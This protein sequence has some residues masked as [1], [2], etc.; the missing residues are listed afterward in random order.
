MVS[1]LKRDELQDELKHRDLKTY[2][3][4]GAL[5]QR[6]NAAIHREINVLSSVE[7]AK[8][9]EEQDAVRRFNF[10]CNPVRS[11]KELKSIARR[12]SAPST[13]LETIL[14]RT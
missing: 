5:Q 3:P 6:L 13:L 4:N 9:R 8:Q 14:T 1:K 2:G 7:R 10:N 11:R 12:M